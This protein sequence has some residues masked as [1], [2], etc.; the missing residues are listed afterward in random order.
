VDGLRLAP[1]I[2]DAGGEGGT[3]GFK[4]RV[5]EEYHMVWGSA[6]VNILNA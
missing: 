6:S 1:N 3:K 4:Q 2:D 5:K